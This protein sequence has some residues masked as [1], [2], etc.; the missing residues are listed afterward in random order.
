MKK[1]NHLLK[2][3]FLTLLI[4]LSLNCLRDQNEPPSVILEKFPF[5][6]GLTLT[7]N[8]VHIKWTGYDSDGFIIGFYYDL[9]RNPP[10]TF[11]E[12]KEVTFFDLESGDYA[13]YIYSVDNENSKSELY[14]NNFTIK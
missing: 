13:F 5:A 14:V 12:E 6:G 1:L 8:D 9:N 7:S 10:K 4:G 3:F 11:T 2:Y